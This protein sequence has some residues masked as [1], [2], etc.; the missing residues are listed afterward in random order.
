LG[1][2]VFALLGFLILGATM[3]VYFRIFGGAGSRLSTNS[4]EWANFGTYVG[5]VAGPL[6]SYLALVAVIWTVRLQYDL[7]QRDREKQISDQHVR[8]LEATYQ[9]IL[10][11]VHAP[12]AKTGDSGFSTVWSV[13]NGEAALSTVDGAAFSIRFMELF[14]LLTQYCKAVGLYRDNVSE[15]FDATI[16]SDRGARILDRLKP[17]H[18]HLGSMSPV[19]FEFLDMH[20][21][22]EHERQNA[23]AM[24]RATRT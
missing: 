11:L 2:A 17:F 21:R 13:L 10:E 16:F 8:W 15:F 19:T 14:K 18:K 7:L 12:L 6:L 3:S 22:G 1:T 20:L 24:K 5:G 9:D 23:E 4:V